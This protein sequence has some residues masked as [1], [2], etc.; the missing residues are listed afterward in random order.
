MQEKIVVVSILT[1]QKDTT[2]TFSYPGWPF[3]VAI[4]IFDENKRSGNDFTNIYFYVESF[5]MH[6]CSL[7]LIFIS[8]TAVTQGMYII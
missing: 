4:I 2:I 3:F 8:L 5:N 7:M 1:E 6:N